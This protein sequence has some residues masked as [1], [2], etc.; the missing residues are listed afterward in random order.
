MRRF[1]AGCGTAACLAASALVVACQEAPV[2]GRS[3]LVL[4]SDQQAAQLGAQAYQQ[5]KSQ[6][7]V[8]Q[9][10]ELNARMMA[11]GRRIAAAVGKGTSWEFTLFEDP[12]ANAFAL[13]GGK[14]GVNTGLFKVAKTD[15]QLAAVIGHEIAHVMADHSAERLSRDVVTQTALQGLGVA[16][17]GGQGL[18]QLAAAAAQLGVVLPFTRSQEAEADEI[19]LHYMARAG[20]DPHEAVA[21]WQ[22]MQQAGGKGPPEFLSTHPAPGNRIEHLRALM[23]KVVPIYQ[24]NARR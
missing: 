3:Q 18:V 21:L 1:L 4:I 20:Y 2:T 15:A 17:G 22:N 7:K 23:P 24:Q 5:I 12:T 11:V 6:Q 10:A 8:S 14:V 13:P 9:N 16:A 19:G